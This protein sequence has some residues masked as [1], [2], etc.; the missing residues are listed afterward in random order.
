MNWTEYLELSEKTLSEEFHIGTKVQNTLHAV[1]GL[2]T[3]IE[4]ILENYTHEDAMDSTNMLE[5]IGDL[6]WYLAI[7]HREYPT[8]ERFEN[9]T[10]STDRDKPFDCVL[11]L[12]K[13]SLRLLDIMKKKIFYNKPIDETILSGLVLLVETDIH[14]LCKYYNITVGDVCQVNI[15]KLK[16]R[17][18][19]KFT[20]DRAINRDLDNERDIL[21]AGDNLS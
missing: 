4:E 12:N 10:V 2:S 5:E 3:E 6:T 18:G 7:L 1:M 8:I 13:S 17:Y 20:S 14:W 16:S 11:D 15:D 21:E 19:D 9:T